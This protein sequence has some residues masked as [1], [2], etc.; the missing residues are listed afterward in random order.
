MMIPEPVLAAWGFTGLPIKLGRGL[1]NDTYCISNQF[2]LQRINKRVFLQ[3][4]EVVANFKRV[5][6]N[7]RDLVPRLITTEQGSDCFEDQNGDVWRC[8]E[9]YRSRNFQSVPDEMVHVAGQAFGL[10]LYRLRNCDVSLEPVI[11]NFHD[12]RY[13]LNELEEAWREDLNQLDRTLIERYR[14][15]VDEK[16]PTGPEQIIHGDCKVN[17]LLFD[18]SE[19]KVIRIVDTDTL[20]WG[21]PVWDF[22]DLV[23]SIAMGI[24]S[25]VR[26]KHRISSVCNGF[27][28]KF[29]VTDAE[30]E[31]Y[32][33]APTY[34]S[35]ML[36]VRFLTD[37][38][39]GNPYFKVN[40]EGE[41]MV[42]ALEQFE[43]AKTLNSHEGELQTM[44]HTIARGL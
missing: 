31:Y 34:M 32:A 40:Q 42:R 14:K 23:R 35:M 43:L 7:V 37:H 25:D 39:L 20:M 41:N 16:A 26:L 2:V 44:I 21:Y 8:S 10:F 33:F 11:P 13:Y 15:L 36:G 5:Y 27:F 28:E 4:K 18:L 17:N 38:F 30:M 1:I 24:S 19:N 9:Y 12:F 6:D 22:G 3:P 29:P